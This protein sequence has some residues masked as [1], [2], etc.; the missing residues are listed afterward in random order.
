MIIVIIAPDSETGCTIVLSLWSGTSG[1][2]AASYPMTEV[3]PTVYQSPNITGLNGEWRVRMVNGDDEPVYT[4]YVVMTAEAQGHATSEPN[5][6]AEILALIGG[7]QVTSIAPVTSAGTI[8]GPI[9]IG[10][11][12]LT[13]SGRSFDW[14]IAPGAFDVGQAECW[15]GGGSPSK[16]SWLVQG[17][18]SAVTVDG[19]PRWR[20]RFELRRSDTLPLKPAC[21]NWSVELRGPLPEHITRII[22]KAEVVQSYTSEG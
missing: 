10:D 19:Q 13:A 8:N 20:L 18:V 12:Y 22:G 5:E 1:T 6:N 3:A 7:G 9:V 11:D 4:G 2:P 17:V 16:P 14:L 15:F 21:Y